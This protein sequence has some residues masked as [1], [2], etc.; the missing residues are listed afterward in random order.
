MCQ[1]ARATRQVHAE[2]CR[3]QLGA[4]SNGQCD[5]KEERL[6]SCPALKCV[7]GEDHDDQDQHDA[8]QQVAEVPD[9]A[10]ELGFG[11]PE[12]KSTGDGTE[13]GGGTGMCDEAAGCAAT[14]VGSEKH[15][16]GP[17]G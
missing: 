12:H 16:V 2:D 15:T 10:I 8:R 17:L 6:D 7:C 14:N 9:A 4:Q 11:R 1:H 5:R 13:L 3:Q